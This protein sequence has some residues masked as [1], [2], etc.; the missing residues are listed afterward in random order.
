[1]SLWKP[2]GSKFW[3]YDFT[4]K[5]RRYYGSSGVSSKEKAK[6]IEA[7]VRTRAAEEAAFGKPKS[8][9]TLT[10]DL[11]FGRYYQEVSQHTASAK[12][13]L[14]RIDALME[15]L[16]SSTEIQDVTDNELAVAVAKLRSRTTG[17]G[18]NKKLISNATVNRY[19][20]FYRRVWKLAAKVWK[21]E[22]G[23]EPLW[24]KLLL[25]EAD[26]RIRSLSKDE[27][28]GL[29]DELREDYAP[30]IEFAL[31][32][33][34]R[35]GNLRSMMWKDVDWNA[36]EVKIR[37]KSRKPGGR[38]HVVPLTQELI[39]LLQAERGKH[40]TYVFTYL[41]QR[42]RHSADGKIVRKKGERYQF[43]KDGWRRH[44][45]EALKAAGIE[46]FRFH[47]TRHTAATRI[48]RATGNLKI[49]QVLLGH[50]DIATTARYA[51]VDKFD[52]R[53]A[54]MKVSQGITKGDAADAEN[55]EEHQEVKKDRA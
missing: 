37:M 26:E 34:I 13:D 14:A 30:L 6:G 27:Q 35:C 2:K 4:F 20:E 50:T 39:D 52:I 46:D 25:Q 5:G 33:G 36:Q 54:M 32:T 16:G 18:G 3:Y 7:A 31:K 49:A 22:C 38:T 55:V 19:I 24:S 44:W 21:A 8:K 1:M 12:N 43:S 15:L 17:L 29:F 45:K 53:E 47:D 42:P 23:D 28:D 51:H 40:F 41:C 9:P 10:L 11:A 48:V